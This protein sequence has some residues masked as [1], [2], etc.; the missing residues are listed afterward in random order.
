MRLLI[1]TLLKI[2]RFIFVFPLY[3]HIAG[4]G[5]HVEIGSF[6]LLEGENNMRFYIS[7]FASCIAKFLDREQITVNLISIFAYDQFRNAARI[8]CMQ[9]SFS[10]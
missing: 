7:W 9:L 10:R 8:G 3:R 4:I 5:D 6:L 1:I 2:S